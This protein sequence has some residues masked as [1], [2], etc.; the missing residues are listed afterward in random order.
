[1]KAT[2]NKVEVIVYESKRDPA[3]SRELH[4]FNEL[5]KRLASKNILIRRY[6]YTEDPERFRENKDLCR[7]IG[8]AGVDMLPVTYVRGRI[9]KIEAYPTKAEIYDWLLNGW[10]YTE[11]EN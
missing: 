11:K 2:Q 4:R 10:K 7:L 9:V 6:S 1:M 8:Y 3:G 5:C